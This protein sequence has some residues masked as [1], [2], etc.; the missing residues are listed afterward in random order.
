VIRPHAIP[1][2]AAAI[3]LLVA[4]GQACD[5]PATARGQRQ[6]AVRPRLDELRANARR[7]GHCASL[8]TR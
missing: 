4:L 2:A 8:T 1:A 7:R 3:L 5:S 6:S